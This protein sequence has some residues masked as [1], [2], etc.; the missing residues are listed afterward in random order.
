MDGPRATIKKIARLAPAMRRLRNSMKTAA[1]TPAFFLIMN[2]IRPREKVAQIRLMPRRVARSTRDLLNTLAQI[3]EHKA[4]FRSLADTSA[5]TT[6]SH[7]RLMLI[8]LGALAKFER[9][10]IC[11]RTGEGPRPRQGERHEDGPQAEAQP[12]P[13]VRGDPATG[14]RTG[15]PC[16][17]WP[18][19][20]CQRMDTFEAQIMN[21]VHLA[22]IDPARNMC[23]FY[24]L[25]YQPELL[26]DFS[27]GSTLGRLGAPR[28]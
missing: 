20:Q 15:D 25:D 26:S 3:A 23:R 4:G 1:L 14:Q 16:R 13:A 7:G 10:L 19:L 24:R 22:R 27:D 12:I 11:A 21:A 18:Q 5:D 9:D 8:V 6:S 17:D 2:P 28:S